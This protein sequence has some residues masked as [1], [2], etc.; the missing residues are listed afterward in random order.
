MDNYTGFIN[1]YAAYEDKYMEKRALLET[2]LPMAAQHIPSLAGH[3]PPD[4]VVGLAGLAGKYMLL[5][6]AGKGIS[7]LKDAHALSKRFGGGIR[8]GLKLRGTPRANMVLGKNAPSNKAL[9]VI[10]KVDKASDAASMLYNGAMLA[11]HLV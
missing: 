6:G 2:L 11:R 3:L 8:E 9:A 10:G 7:A 4:G 5:R 1:K